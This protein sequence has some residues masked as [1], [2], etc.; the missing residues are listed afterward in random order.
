M[1]AAQHRLDNLV[2]ITDY[3][4][5]QID[6]K[7]SEIVSLEPLADKWRSFGWEVFEMDGHD[8]DDIYDTLNR[9]IAAGMERILEAEVRVPDHSQVA[10][11]VG[12]AMLGELKEL[13]PELIDKRSRSRDAREPL[14]LSLS[15][16]PDF[17]AFR[18][19]NRNGVEV[20]LPGSESHAQAREAGVSGGV[21]FALATRSTCIT[22]AMLVE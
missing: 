11:A 20:F 14:R 6:A 12:A 18:I 10:G 5:M 8:W 7:I 13:R 17:D 19:E 22:S 1:F 15:S 4:K 9:A 16:Y 3:N 21:A 2:V